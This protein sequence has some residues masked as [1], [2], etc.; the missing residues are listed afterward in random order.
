MKAAIVT[1]ERPVAAYTHCVDN[2]DIGVQFL[3]L[4]SVALRSQ[5]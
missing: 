4:Y 2:Y 3:V 1:R 5:A